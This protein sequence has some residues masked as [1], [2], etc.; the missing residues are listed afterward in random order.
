MFV[1]KVVRKK[2]NKPVSMS[3]VRKGLF[4]KALNDQPIVFNVSMM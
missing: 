4:I 1:L 2:E 3:R